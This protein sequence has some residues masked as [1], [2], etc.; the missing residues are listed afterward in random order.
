MRSDESEQPPGVTDLVA[1]LVD[2]L[3][4]LIAQHVTLARI[5][6]GEEAR[7]V[8]RSLGTLALFTPLLVVGYAMLCFGV[9]FALVPLLSL[10]GA[11]L[12][13]GAVN[14]VAGGLGLWRVIK[15]LKR[16]HLEDSAAA[17]RESTEL[18]ATPVRVRAEVS[19][20]H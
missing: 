5:E 16:P 6:L 3:G 2:G 14:V 8:S 10:S 4:Q 12:L 18:L 1:K 20:V 11:V 17:A 19:G 13:V 15:V 7:T 9:A